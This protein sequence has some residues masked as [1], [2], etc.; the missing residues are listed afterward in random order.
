ML[1]G[2]R[3]ILRFEFGLLFFSALLLMGL[4]AL[5]CP[6]AST[7]EPGLGLPYVVAN[8]CLRK[9]ISSDCDA[10]IRPSIH[11]SINHGMNHRKVYTPHTFAFATRSVPR[12]T[13]RGSE[14]FLKGGIEKKACSPLAVGNTP[15]TRGIFA[16]ICHVLAPTPAKHRSIPYH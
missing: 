12:P 2:A 15:Q 16:S 3:L 9:R 13:K 11:A 8:I 7:E 10:S 4:W 1:I 6:L 14:K 5:V